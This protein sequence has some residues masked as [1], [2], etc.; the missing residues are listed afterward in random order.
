MMNRINALFAR[1]QVED[2][3]GARWPE[4][5]HLA[6]EDKHLAAAVLLVE[7]ACMDGHFDERERATIETALG[8]RFDLNEEEIASLMRLAESAQDEA[9]HLVRFTR[10]V[11]DGSSAE[12]RIEL[13]EMLWE[14]VY[15]DGE[16]HD[17]E[18]NLVRR[19]GGLL[20]VSDRDRGA[21]RKRVLARLAA[22]RE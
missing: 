10:S 14:V 9:N 1:G 19:I 18:A 22:A 20:Y 6:H 8:A 2:N 13:I 3:A 16:L 11:K 12:E 4:G 7:A 15:A 17:Y 21:A 5:K